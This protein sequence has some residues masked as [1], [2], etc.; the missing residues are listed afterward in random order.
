MAKRKILQASRGKKKVI[1]YT[2]RKIYFLSDST[3]WN[4]FKVLK[5]ST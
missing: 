2:G 3:Q 4:I 1:G 5:L